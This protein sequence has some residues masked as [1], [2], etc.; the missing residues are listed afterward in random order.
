ML[1][2]FAHPDDEVLGAGA[3]LARHAAAGDAVHILL[4][5]DGE[6]SRGG[7][8]ED[9]VGSRGQAAAT[10]AR[11]LGAAPPRLL[12]LPDQR[13]DTVPLLDIVREI[14]AAAAAISP[15]IVYTHH[16][17][18]LNAD[19]RIVCGAAMTAFRPQPGS[20]VRAIYA[21]EIASSTEWSPPS[22]LRGFKPRR[23]IDV[24]ATL[25]KKIEALRCYE[26]EMREFPHPRS[27][28]AVEALAQWRGASAGLAAAEAFDVLRE[29]EPA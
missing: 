22:D 25:A 7:H 16:P 29:I 15:A 10:A 20:A 23:F 21:C 1:A 26:K 14:E 12:G 27:Y 6:T 13:L 3:T 4:L 11:V 2:V 18:D 19:H 5:A 17:D 8:G 28:R 9:R 24:S